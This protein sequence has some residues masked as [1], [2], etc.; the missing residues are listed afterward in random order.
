VARR[1]GRHEPARC[2]AGT[3]TERRPSP[4]R[5]EIHVPEPLT[6]LPAITLVITGA[7]LVAG[8]LTLAVTRRPTLAL[9]V[10]LDLL[11]AAG[12][13]RLVGTP[14]GQALATA[15]AI[16]VIR[17]LVST[18]LRIGGRSLTASRRPERWGAGGGLVRRLVRPAWRL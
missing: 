5:E 3:P 11:L 17:R 13:L 16:V 14:D 4:G 1:T 7:A 8:T 10:F 12:L 6:A 9:G 2:P 15:A 18:G